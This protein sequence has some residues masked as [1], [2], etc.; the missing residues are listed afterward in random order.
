LSDHYTGFHESPLI[1]M[2]LVAGSEYNDSSFVING[3]GA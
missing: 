2:D 1:V 3:P